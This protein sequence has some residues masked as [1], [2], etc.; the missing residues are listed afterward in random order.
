VRGGR[1]LTGAAALA[2]LVGACSGG[3]GGGKAG[4]PEHSKA[5]QAKV[6]AISLRMS[7]L[8]PEW[9]SSP[10]TDPVA[11]EGDDSRY[12]ECVGRPD[13]KTVRTA[14]VAS[15]QFHVDERLRAAST[16]RAL[17]TAVTA[18]EDFD[19]QEGARGL[20]CMRQRVQG[21]IDR[22]SRGGSAPASFTV[23]RLPG[24]SF[25]DRTVG[26]RATLVY[27]PGQGVAKGHL[28]FVNV[29]RDRIEISATFF[30]APD[31]FPPDLERDVVAKMVARA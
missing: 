19:A 18:K 4:G 5:D 15:P 28:D 9:A 21:Q 16:V 8:P 29:L 13:P 30:S 11:E 10:P 12:A 1:L 14:T 20:P 6:D 25:G 24:L 31:P 26:F 27:P 22:Q 23:E 7:D 17:P 3:G 2:L